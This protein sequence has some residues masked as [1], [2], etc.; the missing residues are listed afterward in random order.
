M[1]KTT[2][3][4]I[5]QQANEAR[6]AKKP[7][8]PTPQPVIQVKTAPSSPPEHVICSCGHKDKNRPCGKC[9]NAAQE[10]KR[11]RRQAKRD[12]NRAAA[13]NREQSGFHPKRE[14]ERRLPDGAEFHVVYRAET[15]T[16][17]GNLVVNG[18]M[19]QGTAGGVFRLL[20]NLDAKYRSS[21]NGEDSTNAH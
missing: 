1:D 14:G 9:R 7:A 12:A 8:S 13:E 3:E 10:A 20:M 18:A 11:L 4:R 19:I 2:R 6:A 21:L 17:D 5:R 15:K 16:W